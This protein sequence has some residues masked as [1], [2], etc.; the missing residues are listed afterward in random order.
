VLIY[1][2]LF[3]DYRVH[4]LNSKCKINYLNFY[5]ILNISFFHQFLDINYNHLNHKLYYFT[6]NKKEVFIVK[7]GFFKLI[8]NHFTIHDFL[9]LLKHYSYINR[10]KPANNLQN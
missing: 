1:Q 10:E 7:L 2:N 3:F 4:F 6:K 8:Q 9:L 5:L